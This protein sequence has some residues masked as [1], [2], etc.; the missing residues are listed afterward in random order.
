MKKNKYIYFV[1]LVFLL[2]ILTVGCGVV[3]F[4]SNRYF[5]A[6]I[7]TLLLGVVFIII[8]IF[9]NNKEK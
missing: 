9:S 3:E 2:T 8:K 1:F 4:D 6:F 7:F 5:G